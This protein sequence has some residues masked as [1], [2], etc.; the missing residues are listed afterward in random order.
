MIKIRSN[1]KKKSF[2]PNLYELPND[3]NRFSHGLPHGHRHIPSSPQGGK[4]YVQVWG[5]LKSDTCLEYLIESWSYGNLYVGQN[6]HTKYLFVFKKIEDLFM[7]NFLFRWPPRVFTYIKFTSF[8]YL[9]DL[10]SIKSLWLIEWKYE[11]SLHE[12]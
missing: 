8:Y 5:H 12:S 9:N 6:I 1:D 4:G 7:T 2:E 11:W 10:S 3:I